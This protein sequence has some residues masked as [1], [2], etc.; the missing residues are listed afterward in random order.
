MLW[1]IIIILVFFWLLGIAFK[2][3]GKLIHILIIVALVIIAL[4]LL[5]IV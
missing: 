5:G 3:L 4:R 1:T 2:I